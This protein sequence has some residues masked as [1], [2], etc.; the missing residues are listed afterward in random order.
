MYFTFTD[1]MAHVMWFEKVY[2]WLRFFER[3]VM[4]PAVFL[5][6]VT[7]SSATIIRGEKFSLS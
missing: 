4:F 6:A 7:T 1:D 3:T 5:C 2:V